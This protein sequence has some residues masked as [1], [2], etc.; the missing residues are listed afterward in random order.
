MPA[1]TLPE[2]PPV[3]NAHRLA[4]FIAMHWPGTTYEQAMT[5]DTKRRVIECRAHHLRSQEWRATQQR[6][7]V[8]VTRC[9]P[10]ADGHPTKWCTQLAAGPWAPVQQPDLL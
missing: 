7:V 6:T 1:T 3:T 4:A 9:K 10:G 5:E 8:P 2:L